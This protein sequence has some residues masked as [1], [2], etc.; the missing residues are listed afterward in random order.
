MNSIDVWI[1]VGYLVLVSA[2]GLLASKRAAAS[3]D[4]YFLAGRTLPWW[5]LGISG[6][7]SFIDVGATSAVSGW[8]F[9]AGAKAYWY[10]FNGHIALLLAFQMV[11]VA[12][13]LRRSGCATNAQ[14]MVQRFGRGTPGDAARIITA[15]LALAIAIAFMPFFWTG[16]GKTLAGFIPVFGQ[17]AAALGGGGES[18]IAQYITDVNL[19]AFCFFALIA[20]YTVSSG[21]YGVVYTD[22]LQSFLIFGIIVFFAIQAFNAG[23]PDYFAQYAPEGWFEIDPGKPVVTPEGFVGNKS[24]QTLLQLLPLIGPLAVFWIINN[25]LQGFATPFDAWTAQRYYAAKDEK[26]ASLVAGL[27]ISLLSLR[28]L[29]L[30]AIAILALPLAAKIND[31]EQ[32]LAVVFTTLAPGVAGLVLAALLAAGMSTVDTTVNSCAAY[33]TSDLHKPYLRKHASPK[34]LKRV[35]Y[36]VSLGILVIGG[37]LGVFGDSIVGIW[38]W[39]IMGLFVGTL[40]P[41][42]V[43]W[44]WWRAN[45]WGFA[46]G[47]LTGL[48]I[49]LLAVIPATRVW[50]NGQ[51]YLIFDWALYRDFVLG[52]FGD[53]AE[54][55]GLG[56]AVTF[57]TVFI[58]SAIGTLVFTLATPATDMNTLEAFY[59]R[60]RPFGFWG[61]VRARVEGETMAEINCENRRDLLLLPVA[62]LWQ[63]SLFTL[64]GMVILKRWTIVAVIGVLLVAT[65]A[66]LYQFWFRNLKAVAPEQDQ[67]VA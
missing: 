12:K 53:P 33:Y 4:S 18:G 37:L 7:A 48:A 51:E 26:E 67:S 44:F 8:F 54:L 16:A 13:W 60:V 19:A 14:W 2:V 65:T 6:I 32:A 46:G 58:G 55:A 21:F 64:W 9:V 41:N 3:T 10:M 43:K 35:S 50:V 38:G 30:P 11:F 5:L 57:C 15:V 42:I 47:C 34:E 62:C 40:P 25:F 59:R 31:P 24:S 63:F 27:W 20:I 45:G 49:A 17:W 66:L 61:P 1:V 39:I 29:L 28:W 36:L 52:L 22:F 56:E 23:T